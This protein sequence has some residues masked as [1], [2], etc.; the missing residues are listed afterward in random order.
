M[1]AIGNILL[2][3]AVI[4]KS[5]DDV[6]VGVFVRKNLPAFFTATL[7]ATAAGFVLIFLI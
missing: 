5:L 1:I 2:V 6:G 7:V 4:G 3:K